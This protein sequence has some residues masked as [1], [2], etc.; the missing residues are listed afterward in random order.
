MRF[1]ILASVATAMLILAFAAPAS[2]AEVAQGKCLAFE[3]GKSVSIDEYDTSISKEN[4]YGKTTG[5]KLTFDI[6]E[7]LVGITPAPGDILRIAYDQKGDQLK[8]LRV[9]NVTKQDLMTK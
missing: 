8:A 2:A 6:S 5:K 4:K 9:M 1:K 3:A 7:A